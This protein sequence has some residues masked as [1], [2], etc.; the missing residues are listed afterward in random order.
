MRGLTL[1][2]WRLTLPQLHHLTQLLVNL[3]MT[4]RALQLEFHKSLMQNQKN[5]SWILVWKQSRKKRWGSSRSWRMKN[6]THWDWSRSHPKDSQLVFRMN[7]M[8]TQKIRLH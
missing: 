4:L 2:C 8:L 5:W 1:D 3:N 6:W 7:L